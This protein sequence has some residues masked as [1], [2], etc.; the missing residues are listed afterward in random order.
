[1]NMLVVIIHALVCRKVIACV[2]CEYTRLHDDVHAMKTMPRHGWPL[3][4]LDF[5][6]LHGEAWSIL[7]INEVRECRR[8]T[9]ESNM[10]FVK[11]HNA[12]ADEIG[13]TVEMN[14]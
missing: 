3:Q 10:Q 14:K 11:E 8:I 7:R 6:M 2:L 5:S 13:F 9:W 12:H 1:M 4:C